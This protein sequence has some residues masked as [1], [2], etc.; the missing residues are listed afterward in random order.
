M[1]RGSDDGWGMRTKEVSVAWAGGASEVGWRSGRA[2]LA[3]VYVV[4][5]LGSMIMAMLLWPIS[6]SYIISYDV[7]YIVS[8]II[9]YHILYHI[10]SYHMYRI[11]SH[12]IWYHL[13]PYHI[14][15]QNI[16]HIISYILSNH[17]LLHIIS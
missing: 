11:S 9:L 14:S 1:G 8:Y 17:I 4:A 6:I 7:S 16:H 12:C 13:I 5:I 2:G 3:A 10:I 15:Y